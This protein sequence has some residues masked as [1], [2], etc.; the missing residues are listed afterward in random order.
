M[1][2]RRAP[3]GAFLLRLVLGAFVASAIF[4]GFGAIPSPRHLFRAWRG[5]ETGGA[6]GALLGVE[7]RP[8]A[9]TPFSRYVRQVA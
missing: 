1:P 5:V 9:V 4:W 8:R 3:V 6:D 2:V 7:G